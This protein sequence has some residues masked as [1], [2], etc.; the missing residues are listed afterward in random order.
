MLTFLQRFSLC[1]PQQCPD[2]H[3]ESPQQIERQISE[4]IFQIL[5]L[6]F[7]ICQAV[8]HSPGC[9]GPLWN[10][11]PSV[12]LLAK[13][14]ICTSSDGYHFTALT[15]LWS[16]RLWAGWGYS[17][18]FRKESEGELGNLGH[19]CVKRP[20]FHLLISSSSLNG[21]PL[22]NG[23]SPAEWDCRSSCIYSFLCCLFESCLS[24][25]RPWNLETIFI[26]LFISK[27]HTEVESFACSKMALNI[28]NTRSD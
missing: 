14:T 3:P 27:G 23:T 18:E 17:T 12:K 28:R 16:A 15:L 22:G 20:N 10:S 19:L 8:T 5:C 7:N 2:F 26:Y 1:Y 11:S 4:C 9:L 13:V 24:S 21:G 25:A 6:L